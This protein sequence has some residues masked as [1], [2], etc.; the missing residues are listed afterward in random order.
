MGS[1]EQA[2]SQLSLQIEQYLQQ[3]KKDI[4][5]FQVNIANVSL[6]AWLKSQSAYPQFYLHFRDENKSIAALGAVRKFSSLNLA[7]EFIEHF[8]FPLLGGLQFQGCGQFI[9]PQLLLETN[10]QHTTISCFVEG[11]AS[12]Q[13]TLAQLKTLPKMTALCPLPKQIPLYT[14]QGANKQ[15]WC[16]WVNQ[17]L[18]E[19][20]QGELTKLVLANERVFHL[21]QPVN[22]YDFLA[23]SE[24]HNQGCYH[25]LWAENPRSTFVGSTPERLFAREY[26]LFLTEALA[27]TAP[28]TAD[29]KENQQQAQW[30]L[31]DEKN[32]NENWLVVQ[33]ISQNIQAM[34]ESFDVSEVELKPLRKVQHLLRKIRANLTAHY[35]DSALL[36]AIH[37]TAAVS[38]LP[39]Q[40]ARMILSEIET[41][42]RGWYAGTLGVMSEAYS[43]FCVAIRSA[44]I[45]RNRIRVFAGAGIVEGSEPLAEWKEIERK[46]SGLISLFAENNDGEKE[47]L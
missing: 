35:R 10:E 45:E 44:F 14:E 33:D 41:F 11:K 29:L 34:V 43:E 16:D 9:L 19:I 24:K 20:K 40:Q 28:I 8:H 31:N 21:K 5:R 6:L 3:G 4:E 27:G 15:M 13:S 38:G 18:Y 12:A 7:Q 42:D 47:C 39:Q 37:P 46:A 32:L 17:A 23:E 25:F 26:N 30:L 1:L 2:A 22:P 36:K